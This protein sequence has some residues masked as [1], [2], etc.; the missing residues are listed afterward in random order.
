MGEDC[1]AVSV[2]AKNMM[3]WFVISGEEKI[4]K[5]ANK[6][7]E[8]CCRHTA[9]RGDAI[10]GIFSYSIEGAIVKNLYTSCAFVYASAYAIELENLLLDGVYNTN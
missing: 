5:S 3:D 1:K 10:G 7:L 4:V 8:W 6:A 2:I 9:N